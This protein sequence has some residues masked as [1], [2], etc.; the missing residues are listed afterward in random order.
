MA[1]ILI[2]ILI[3]SVSIKLSLAKT[4]M[5]VINVPNKIDGVP[6]L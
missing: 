2:V 4:T 5:A 6:S 3:Q 1:M